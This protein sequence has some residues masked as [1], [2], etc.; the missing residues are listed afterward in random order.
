[1]CIGTIF[2]Q[3]YKGVSKREIEAE[4][5]IT[6]LVVPDWLKGKSA[7]MKATWKYRV[8]NGIRYAAMRQDLEDGMKESCYR[9]ATA[10]LIRSENELNS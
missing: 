4:R 7:A 5:R 6:N 1:V 2:E 8:G 3:T 10:L 9:T